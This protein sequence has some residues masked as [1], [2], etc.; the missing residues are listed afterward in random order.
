MTTLTATE[1]PSFGEALRFWWKLGWISFGGTAA[2]LGIMHEELVENKKWIGNGVFLHALS[3]CMLLP[4]PEAQELAIYIGHR[5]HGIRG[6][7]VAGTLFVLPSTIVLLAF[8]IVYVRFGTVPLIASSF[9]GLKPVVLAL[10]L[11]A[12]RRVSARALRRPLQWIVAA[13]TFVGMFFLS[14]P[15]TSILLGA[16]VLGVAVMAVRPSLV[17]TQDDEGEAIDDEP[18]GIANGHSPKRGSAPLAWRF[19]KLTAVALVLWLL[20]LPYLYFYGIDF[21]YWKTAAL[22]FTKTAFVTVGGSYTVIPYVA[23]IAVTKFHWLSSAQM[24]DGFALAETTPGPLIIVLAFVGFMAAYNHFQHSL[25]MGTLGL[26]L[27]TFYTFL[28]PFWFVFAGAPVMERTHSAPAIK[29]VLALITAVVV[30]AMLDL[31]LFIAKGVLFPSNASG[32]QDMDLLTAA[33]AL[34][35]LVLLARF[36]LGVGYGILLGIVSG[37][38]RYAFGL[39]VG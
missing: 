31:L 2:H 12:L 15:V 34:V 18:A 16:I 5:L 14:L 39:R 28:P 9:N 22:F 11:L 33:S 23:Q 8:S 25:W 17:R 35:A 4:G 26:L 38:L 21:P 29:G 36:K 7:L 27:T 1:K 32:I 24:T 19:L 6:G 10:L 30:G 20:P 37:A 3:H 13:C